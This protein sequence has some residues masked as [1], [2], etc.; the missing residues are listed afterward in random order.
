MRWRDGCSQMPLVLCAWR[1]I[2]K[3]VATGW[4]KTAVEP[5]D[6]AKDGGHAGPL[7]PEQVG[8]FD[9][10]GSLSASACGVLEQLAYCS[11]L[12]HGSG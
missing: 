6:L 4:R 9:D 1:K 3:S 8:E 11:A 5:T 12:L 2:A 10:L 7:P